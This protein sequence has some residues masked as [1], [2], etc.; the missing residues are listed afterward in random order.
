MQHN[1]KF[2]DFYDSLLEFCEKEESMFS[3]EYATVKNYVDDGY[4]GKGW[5]HYD[6]DL[7][8][9]IWPIEEASWLRLAHSRQRLLKE[10]RAIL[11]YFE[12]ELSFKTSDAVLYDLARFQV[13]LLTYGG[14]FVAIITAVV[15]TIAQF[16]DWYTPLIIWA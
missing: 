8:D 16:I 15:I 6:L 10:I 2:I 9:I 14:I 5:D 12:N 1:I 4:A 13:F 3:K 7:G 11:N